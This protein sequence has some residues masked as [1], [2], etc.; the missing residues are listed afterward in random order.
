M[1][2]WYQDRWRN[3]YHG[4]SIIADSMDIYYDTKIH[5]AWSTDTS[6]QIQSRWI[7]VVSGMNYIFVSG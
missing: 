1:T 3:I 5:F 7:T 2:Y 6:I 4:V